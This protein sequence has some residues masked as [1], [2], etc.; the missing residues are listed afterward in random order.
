MYISMQWVSKENLQNM[1]NKEGPEK[2]HGEG[3]SRLYANSDAGNREALWIELRKW[4]GFIKNIL[5]NAGL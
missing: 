4:K 1:Q 3:S 2:N 5:R